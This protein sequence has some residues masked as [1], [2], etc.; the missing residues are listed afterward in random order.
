MWTAS[1]RSRLALEEKIM[2]RELGNFMFCDRVCNTYVQGLQTTSSCN[3]YELRLTFPAYYPDQR[4]SLYV[5]YPKALRKYRSCETLDSLG[6][7]HAFHILGRGPDGSLELCHF[8]ADEW[9]ASK[10]CVA[11]LMKGIIWC[12]LYDA[13]LGTGKDIDYFV[14]NPS[15]FNHWFRYKSL[16]NR[17]FD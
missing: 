8:N 17:R 16:S 7:S 6:T 11:V 15:E 9:D 1:Q 14:S 13:H 5:T 2:S 3:L 4:P 10:T 12:E